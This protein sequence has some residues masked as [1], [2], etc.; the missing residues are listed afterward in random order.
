M[1]NHIIPVLCMMAL[2]GAVCIVPG[3]SE[4]GSVEL[5]EAWEGGAVISITTGHL[6]WDEVIAEG[7]LYQ[8]VRL[9]GFESTGTLGQPAGISSR[10]THGPSAPVVRMCGS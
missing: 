3:V 4:A 7:E 2:M 9:R 8:A 5:L 10:V 6:E 1:R